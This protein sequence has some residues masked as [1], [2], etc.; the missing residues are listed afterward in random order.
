MDVE[1]ESIKIKNFKSLED[2]ILKFRDLTIIVG[3]NSSGKSNSLKALFFLKFLVENG[4]SRYLEEIEKL[5][6]IDSEE[7]KIEFSMNLKIYL[8]DNEK[9]K[10]AEYRVTLSRKNDD[11]FS[12]S[13]ELLKIGSIKVID[14]TNGTGIVR[15]DNGENKQIYHSKQGGLALRTAGDFGDKPLTSKISDFIKKW[16]FYNLDPEIIRNQNIYNDTDI[17]ERYKLSSLFDTQGQRLQ[18][19]IIFWFTHKPEILLNFNR[20]VYD[21]LGIKLEICKNNDNPEIYVIEKNNLKVP[22]LDISDGTVRMIAYCA[23]L[24]FPGLRTL[25]GIEEPERNLHPAVLGEVASLLKRL[26]QQ[27]QVVITTHS[28]QFLDCFSLEEIQNDVSVLLLT[29]KSNLGTQVIPLDE[30]G[31]KREDLLEWMQDFGVGSAIYHSNLL[32][33]CLEGENA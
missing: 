14:V 17:R 31:K 20:E 1:L 32:Q 16:R 5:V 11:K 18:N 26:S 3:A 12:C 24:M 10:M 9:I 30:L 23:L 28:S 4:D 27:N 2:V 29:Q 6:K 21:C 13:R 8:E 25:V 19:S 33:E 22:F 7:K 15:D